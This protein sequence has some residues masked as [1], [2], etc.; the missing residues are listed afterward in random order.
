[1]NL[2]TVEQAAKELSVSV[3]TVRAWIAQRK[4]GHVRLGRAVRVPAAE[5]ARLIERGTVPA[6]P[7]R[8]RRAV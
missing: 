1:M 6:A 3:H 5:I 4:I 7:E 2:K 8:F